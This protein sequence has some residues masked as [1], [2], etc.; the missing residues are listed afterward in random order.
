MSRK[1][2]KTAVG[3]L[4]SRE[5]HSDE[6]TP[7]QQTTYTVEDPEE[8]VQRLR[9]EQLGKMQRLVPGVQRFLNSIKTGQTPQAV[10]P[11]SGGRLALKAPPQNK[12]KRM[13]GEDPCEEEYDV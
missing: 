1:S 5:E 12:K 6:E 8:E 11:T 9:E 7:S 10:F 2:Q 3:F 13:Y 4:R